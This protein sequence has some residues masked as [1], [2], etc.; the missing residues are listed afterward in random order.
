M[1]QWNRKRDVLREKYCSE[2]ALSQAKEL[3]QKD[4]QTEEAFLGAQG[5]LLL[6]GLL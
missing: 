2:D 5:I 3:L 1:N 6:H 4:E